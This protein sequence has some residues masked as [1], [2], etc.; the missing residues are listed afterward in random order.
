MKKHNSLLAIILTVSTLSTSFA[1]G[2]ISAETEEKYI[3]S[4]D[5]SELSK[6]QLNPNDYDVVAFIEFNYPSINLT[7]LS[8]LDKDE[9]RSRVKNYYKSKNEEL[10]PASDLGYVSYSYVAP[11][12]E[13]DYDSITEYSIERDQLIDLTNSPNVDSINIC[14][15][16]TNVDNN[17]NIS[18]Q[19]NDDPYYHISDVYSDVGIT[20]RTTY[21]GEGIKVGIL[22]DDLP[23][24]N[25]NFPNN[26]VTTYGANSK[27]AHA[28]N[29]MSLIGGKYGLAPNVSF[30]CAAFRYKPNHSDNISIID[31]LNWLLITQS[32]DIINISAFLATYDDY[33]INPQDGTQ[34]VLRPNATSSA[35]YTNMCAYIDY[36]ITTTGCLIVKAAGNWGDDVGTSYYQYITKPGMSI[37]SLTVGSCNVD[38]TVSAFSSFKVLNNDIHKPEVVAPGEKI[39]L[40]NLTTLSGTSFSAPIVTAIAAKLM[41]EFPKLKTNPALLKAAIMAGCVPCAD[42]TETLSDKS[43]YGIVNYEKSRDF[44]STSQYGSTYVDQYTSKDTVVYHE[45]IALSS[46][47]SKRIIFNRSILAGDTCAGYSGFNPDSSNSVIDPGMIKYTVTVKDTSGSTIYNN[48]AWNDSTMLLTVSNKTAY[49]K[50]YEIIISTTE[51]TKKRAETIAVIH[52]SHHVHCY[53]MSYVANDGRTHRA[54][55]ICGDP[56]I[57]VHTFNSS[58]VCTKCKMPK[59]F[60]S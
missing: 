6:N 1:F 37:N 40:P 16:S 57:E 50:E 4:F 36:A 17:E 34:S 3:E 52:G 53:D 38:K 39:M 59:G 9:R 48:I 14:I 24:S 60:F 58:N 25:A 44:I 15:T 21:N 51:R 12:I 19:S 29:V 31:C 41:Q 54:D 8:E 47:I 42:Q 11:Y 23:L 26:S 45:K 22:E 20:N 35:S 33:N 56:I 55:C 32:V 30:Y 43:G 49:E 13:I 10:L 46:N 2:K 27:E 7:E 18:T 5:F 28:S